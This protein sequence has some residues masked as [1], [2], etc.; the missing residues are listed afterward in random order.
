MFPLVHQDRE[1]PLELF[2]IWLNLPAKDKFA[3]PHYQMLWAEDIPVLTITDANGRTSTVR[4]IAGE[5]DGRRAP[6]PSPASWANDPQN[7][8]RILLIRMEPRAEIRIPAVTPTI[9]RNL[10]FYEGDKIKVSGKE[11]LSYTRAVIAG[12]RDL[13]LQA[14]NTQCFL[15]LLE[16][17]PI[18]EPIAKY[19][20]FVMNTSEE[21]QDAYR[22]YRQTEFG[23]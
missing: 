17:E 21:I 23:G 12:D 18:N 15:L 7:H 1:N 4:V 9:S 14:G 2:Q 11:I 10:Y 6:F 19:G 3:H 16:G 8:V 22:D 5:W 20:P 13:L